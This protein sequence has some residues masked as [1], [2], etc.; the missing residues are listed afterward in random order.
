MSDYGAHRAHGSGFSR[1]LGECRAAVVRPYGQFTEWLGF[2]GD[3]LHAYFG[4]HA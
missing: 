3:G 1:P 4:L 2:G